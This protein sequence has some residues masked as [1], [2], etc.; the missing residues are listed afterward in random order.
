MS[1][2]GSGRFTP[3]RRVLV[4]DDDGDFRGEVAAVLRGAGY[5]VSEAGGALAAMRAVLAG[6]LDVVVLDLVL[7]DGHGIEVARAFRAVAT[8][9]DICVVAMTG[10]PLSVEFVDPRTFGAE[11]ILLKPLKSRD[12]LSAVA[13]CFG[14]DAW[15]GGV[16]LPTTLPNVESA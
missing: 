3:P 15:A 5:E 14:D 16:D 2:R 13:H 10:H 11:T 9:R 8:T 6:P 4:V 1:S 7:P 12:L